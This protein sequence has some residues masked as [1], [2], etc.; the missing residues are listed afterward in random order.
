[1]HSAVQ[2]FR[3]IGEPTR[4]RILRILLESRGEL[5]VCE[6]VDTLRKPLY[7]ISRNLAVLRQAGLVEER[8]DGK[9]MMYRLH[10]DFLN[11]SLF[12]VLGQLPPG[13]PLYR[14]DLSALERRRGPTGAAR[15]VPRER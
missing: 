2:K 12:A 10:S 4:L 11:D 7:T 8:R 9:F 13:D 5:C 15:C 6:I 14:G 1:M 3:A